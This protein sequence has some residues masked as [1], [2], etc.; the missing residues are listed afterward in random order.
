MVGGDG[1]APVAEEEEEDV[2]VG[3]DA[4]GPDASGGSSLAQPHAADSPAVKTNAC[5]PG[6]VRLFL[7][8]APIAEE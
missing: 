5:Q 6:L 7:P 8:I 1:P 4:D 2:P 3:I